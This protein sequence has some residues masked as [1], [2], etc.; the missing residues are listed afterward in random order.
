MVLFV[1]MFI[2]G[3]EWYD[4]VVDTLSGLGGKMKGDMNI[5]NAYVEISN[6]GKDF[7]YAARMY[8][9]VIISEKFF[10]YGMKTI[11][12]VNISGMAGGEKYLVGGILFK[13]AVDS[14]GLYNSDL[15]ASKAA[16]HDLKSIIYLFNTKSA[17]SLN[18]PLM[19]ICFD[20]SY[21]SV[22]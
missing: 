22:D 18:I 8:G 6:L 10:P 1:F 4:E 20:K 2:L 12:P 13:F 21:F 9:K 11:K 16:G 14:Y 5:M 19:G 3:Y 15:Y 7:E 17:T